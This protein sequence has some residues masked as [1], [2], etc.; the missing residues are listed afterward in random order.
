MTMGSPDLEFTV[1]SIEQ[2]LVG[3]VDVIWLS[4]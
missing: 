1:V 4:R 2:L 3:R